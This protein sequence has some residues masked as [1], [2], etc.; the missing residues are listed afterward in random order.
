MTS[1]KPEGIYDILVG[2][3]DIRKVLSG[4]SESTILKWHTQDGLP[5]VKKGGLW[6]GSRQNIE[7]WW[8]EFAR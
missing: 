7:K 4:V 5:I 6:V 8:V 1:G 3:K 2:M